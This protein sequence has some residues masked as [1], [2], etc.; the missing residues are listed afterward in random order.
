M[1]RP[2]K[3]YDGLIF[4]RITVKHPSNE[5]TSS[6]NVLHNGIC[7]CGN[8]KLFDINELKTG[9][10]VS[11]GCW[12]IERTTKHGLSKTRLSGVWSKMKSRCNNNKA[13]DYKWYGAKGVF[14]CKEWENNFKEFY[15]WSIGSGYMVGL[16]ID[17]INQD[18][19]Y[20]P[21][22][23]R[24]ISIKDQQ[25]NK[26][27]NRVIKYNGSDYNLVTAIRMF[28]NEFHPGVTESLVRSR[29]SGYGWDFSKAIK[30][31]KNKTKGYAALKAE[32]L[33]QGR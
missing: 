1:G 15:D 28:S 8:E 13:K 2:I 22:N 29:I 23:C 19:P 14:V 10:T 3:S 25:N 30:T 31:P 12:K 17:R 32:A 9:A 21:E 5:R 27:N 24:W 33:E 6:G 11:C 4:G 26:K 20:T 16:S 18:G 7:S